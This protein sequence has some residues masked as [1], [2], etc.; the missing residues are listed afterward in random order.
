MFE[1]TLF[2]ISFDTGYFQIEIAS[3]YSRHCFEKVLRT[4]IDLCSIWSG[5][6][7]IVWNW[8]CCGQICGISV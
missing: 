7:A 6:R 1:F 3:V 2:D 4:E 5:G 8:A